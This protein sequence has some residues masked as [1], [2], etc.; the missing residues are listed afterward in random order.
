MRWGRSFKPF[1]R[2]LLWAVL[3]MLMLAAVVALSLL[4]SP[5][6]LSHAPSFSDKWAHLLA[7]FCLMAGA[8]QLYR[9]RL[10]LAV[11]ALSLCLMGAWLEWM[12]AAM[13]LGRMADRGDMAANAAGVL[14]G[15]ATA[16]LPQRDA[17]LGL[18]RR[19]LG[20]SDGGHAA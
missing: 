11:M 13:A 12:Q 9:Q 1:R 7:Y 14:L 16:W 10:A 17:L 6:R 18:E 5:P 19:W 15:L 2:P 4:P 8:V 20:R 3:W